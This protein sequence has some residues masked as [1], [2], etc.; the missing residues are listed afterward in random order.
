MDDSKQ[1]ATAAAAAAAVA[2]VIMRGRERVVGVVGGGIEESVVFGVPA[3]CFG[4]IFVDPL[5]VLC[6][7]VRFGVRG[8]CER[9]GSSL[10]QWCIRASSKG[11]REYGEGRVEEEEKEELDRGG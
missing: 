9:K 11:R 3:W 8:C 1:A 7:G 10:S 4:Y 5:L 6:G 2:V